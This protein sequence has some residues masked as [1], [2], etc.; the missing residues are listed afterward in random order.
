MCAEKK[1]TKAEIR[2]DF[3]DRVYET[4]MEGIIEKTRR[5]KKTIDLSTQQV[6]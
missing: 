2:W 6:S 5:S 3:I 4:N 1:K